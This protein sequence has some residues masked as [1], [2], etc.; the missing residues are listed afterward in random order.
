MIIAIG[1]IVISSQ[2]VLSSTL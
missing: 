1:V 2:V